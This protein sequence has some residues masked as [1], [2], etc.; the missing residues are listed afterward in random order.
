MK[1]EELL[2]LIKDAMRSH[3]KVHLSILRQVHEEIKKIEVDER[4]EVTE[5]DVTNSIKRLVKQ[6][7]ET[8]SFSRQAANDDERT[9]LYERQVAI[10]EELLPAQ[11]SGEALEALAK[12]VIEAGGYSSKREIGAVMKELIEKSEG[13]LDKAEASKIVSGL[14]S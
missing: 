14:L 8:L 5:G 1:K 4:R 9:A 12:E 10:L 13:N 11:L 6:T 2:E 7:G 3:D